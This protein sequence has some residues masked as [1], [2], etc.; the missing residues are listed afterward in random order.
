MK[1]TS[2]IVFCPNC[3]D[4]DQYRPNC[5]SCNGSGRYT[6]TEKMK[7]PDHLELGAKTYRERN[8]EYGDSYHKF[9]RVMLALFPDGLTIETVNKWNRL[10]VL[11]QIVSKLT[12]YSNDF[13][14]PHR[15]S[16]HDIMVYAAMLLE[17]EN[18]E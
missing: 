14:N 5:K 2:A 8:V 11:V 18:S 15:D 3:H 16:I 1:S 13:Y 17:L 12:R 10:G 6:E 9:G 4:N 7:A